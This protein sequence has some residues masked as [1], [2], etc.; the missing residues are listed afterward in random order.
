MSILSDDPT[1]CLYLNAMFLRLCL[2]NS[3]YENKNAYYCQKI[4][5]T[6]CS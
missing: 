2:Y 5:I 6:V 3:T 4:Q 1:Y